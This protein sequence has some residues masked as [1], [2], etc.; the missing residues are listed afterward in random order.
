[1]YLSG[2]EARL[3]QQNTPEEQR[4]LN[5]LRDTL[6]ARVYHRQPVNTPEISRRARSWAPWRRSRDRWEQEVM[7]HLC[8][9]PN[10]EK[11]SRLDT[12]PR[13]QWFCHTESTHIDV[14]LALELVSDCFVNN[15]LDTRWQR[16]TFGNRIVVPIKQGSG[17]SP[18]GYIKFFPQM[19][20]NQLF[21]GLM[22]Y[23]ICGYSLQFTP[24]II[25][26]P[27]TK[28]YY[29]VLVSEARGHALQTV[30]P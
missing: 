28:T 2:L 19:L 30:S 5:F 8:D 27:V 23:Q 6:E 22:G 9:Q 25:F 3:A 12:R 21:A 7:L 20:G 18:V 1:M 29:P 26:H 14:P 17:G 15:Q 24:A 13:L 10:D 16:G 11:Q 4:E